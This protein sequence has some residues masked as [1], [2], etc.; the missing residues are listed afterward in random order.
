MIKKFRAW[1][2]DAVQAGI[3]PVAAVPE[4]VRHGAPQMTIYKIG[5][6]YLV[7][8]QDTRQYREDHPTVVYCATPLDVAR[9][10]I[11]GEALEKLG[12]RPDAPEA[13]TLSG[14]A[15]ATFTN[16]I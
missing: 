11:N 13:M 10:I 9:Q 6:G 12:I 5:N 15:T 16:K 8:K 14:V 1:I 2:A 3:H 4:V 7:H